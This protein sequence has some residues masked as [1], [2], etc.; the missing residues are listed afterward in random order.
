MSKM[1]NAQIAAAVA[2]T[3]RTVPMMDRARVVATL[4]A[5]GAVLC[6]GGAWYEVLLTNATRWVWETDPH[7][8]GLVPAWGAGTRGY[9][10]SI[11][12]VLDGTDTLAAQ[13][14]RHAAQVEATAAEQAAFYAALR[15]TV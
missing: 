1:N 9:A 15:A 11:F 14:A 5:E 2:K 4:R 10:E 6:D 8:T 7:A 3:C 12:A 13:A